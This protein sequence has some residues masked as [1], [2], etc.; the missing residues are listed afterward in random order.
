MGLYTNKDA[1]T[2]NFISSRLTGNKY[3]LTD[4]NNAEA[5]QAE[6]TF[7]YMDGWHNSTTVSSSYPS[8][9]WKRAPSF[10]DV[11]AVKGKTTSG[12]AEGT[13]SH[14][15]GAVP[16]MIWG[17]CRNA[18]RDWQVY[19]KD[20]GPTKNLYLSSTAAAVTDSRF[21]GTTPTDSVFYAG[22]EM[23]NAD[24]NIFYLFAS[25]DGVSKVGS[26]TGNG[27]SQTIDCGFSAGAR[28]VLIKATNI[29]A[30]WL[31][32]DTER[33]IV[34]GND[35]A[36]VLNSDQAEITT[37][38]YIDPDNSGFALDTS[39]GLVNGNGNTYIF[40]AIA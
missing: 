24:D 10:F 34:A 33:G 1:S 28:F 19:H 11:V 18:G 15:L 35:S 38:D 16:E 17:K 4:L 5:T 37:N 22:S 29:T 32:F 9:M 12:N 21:W 8:W 7:D 39:N 13:M 25:L 20:L 23:R 3:L 36:L 40:Y 31:V 30:S 14:N 2:S 6:H 27:G 26:Y